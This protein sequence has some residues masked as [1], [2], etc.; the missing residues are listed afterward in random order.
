MDQQHTKSTVFGYIHRPIKISNTSK[1][2]SGVKVSL[3]YWYG[4]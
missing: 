1:F 4:L 2:A 3:W